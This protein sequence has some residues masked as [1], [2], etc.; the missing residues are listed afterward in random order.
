MEV[1]ITKVRDPPRIIE[2]I[3]MECI[4]WPFTKIASEGTAHFMFTSLYG[5]LKFQK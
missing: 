5:I 1:S 2:V 3:K 4:R